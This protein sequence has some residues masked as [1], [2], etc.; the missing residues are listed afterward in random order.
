M[1][2]D[3]D[4]PSAHPIPLPSGSASER[5]DATAS[6]RATISA[7]CIRCG[8]CVDVCPVALSPVQ[9][10]RDIQ[11]GRLT[12]AREHRL[13][14]CT[15]C[16]RCD[17]VCPSRIPL[18][19]LFRTGRHALQAEERAIV[20]AD[21]ARASYLARQQRLASEQGERRERH[22]EQT[23]NAASADAV[24]AAIE[25]AHARRRARLG[26]PPQ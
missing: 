14:D 4:M 9:L 3:P 8:Q 13:L 16:G 21:A 15:E 6:P 19:E 25:R 2:I 12:L 7:P 10:L 23:T 5:P 11:A 17:P 24:A 26:K 22:A 20:I 1:A 18:L